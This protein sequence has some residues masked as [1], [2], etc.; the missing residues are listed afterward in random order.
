MKKIFRTAAT[1]G[2]L[3]LA[4]SSLS[5]ET[6]NESEEQLRFVEPSGW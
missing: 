5:Q 4:T 6:M 2:S 1:I 3:I